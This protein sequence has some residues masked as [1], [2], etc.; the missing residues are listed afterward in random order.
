MSRTVSSIASAANSTPP[1]RYGAA[2]T[3]IPAA[4]GPISAYPTGCNAI[5]TASRIVGRVTMPANVATSNGRRG[6]RRSTVMPPISEP[7]AL[8]TRMAAQAPAPPKWRLAVSAPSTGKANANVVSTANATIVDHTHV[9]E[10]TS[11]KPSRRSARKCSVLSG[12]ALPALRTPAISTA[13]PRR[14]DLLDPDVARET[15]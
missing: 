10:R 13:L 5:G 12:R 11:A 14:T 9:R 1:Q 15:V 2:D 3:P 8:A 4:S 7:T 6:R